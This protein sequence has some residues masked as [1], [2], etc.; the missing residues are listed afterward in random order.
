MATSTC[1]AREVSSWPVGDS[2]ERRCGVV[3]FVLFQRSFADRP[4]FNPR[5][6]VLQKAQQ[7]STQQAV[8]FETIVLGL[9]FSH[10]KNILAVCLE[11]AVHLIWY[12]NSGMDIQIDATAHVQTR[13][14]PGGVFCLSDNGKMLAYPTEKVAF[15]FLVFCLTLSSLGCCDWSDSGAKRRRRLK[16]TFWFLALFLN[17]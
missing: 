5:R 3:F 7:N 17:F 16:R 2:G 4:D 1:L 9:Q 8:Q 13:V 6:V 10:K 11:N 14:N 15:L 12:T